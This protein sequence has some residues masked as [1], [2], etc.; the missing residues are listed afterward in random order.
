M[1]HVLQLTDRRILHTYVYT[2]LQTQCQSVVW[3]EVNFILNDVQIIE[4]L[5]FKTVIFCVCT[6]LK[7]YL[8]VLW[9]LCDIYTYTCLNKLE[10]ELPSVGITFLLYKLWD[11]QYEKMYILNSLC[12]TWV[13]SILN[14]VLLCH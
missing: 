1:M 8:R 4:I 2:C 11:T 7:R 10:N 5:T 6:H 14:L 3:N 9:L 13:A 12:L